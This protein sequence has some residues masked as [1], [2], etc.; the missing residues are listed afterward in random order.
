M[1]VSLT[2]WIGRPVVS[3]HIAFVRPQLTGSR[4]RDGLCQPDP[5]QVRQS[6]HVSQHD[7]EETQSSHECS[8]KSVC[9][10]GARE[11]PEPP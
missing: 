11:T 9:G 3:L 10:E 6:V 2:W 1:L 7:M 8:P 5:V 4:Y